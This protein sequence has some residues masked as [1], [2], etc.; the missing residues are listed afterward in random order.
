MNRLFGVDVA[1][2]GIKQGTDAA[3]DLLYVFSALEM[4]FDQEQQESRAVKD[5]YIPV[6]GRAVTW[7]IPCTI[8][9]EDTA[10]PFNIMSLAG[11]QVLVKLANASA[12]IVGYEGVATVMNLRHSMGD[13]AQTIAFELVGNGNLAI[14][15]TAPTAFA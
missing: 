2:Y 15:S 13:A 1:M 10:L 5:T 14:N 12:G 4:Q 7:R 11:K 8:Q 3:L 6:I 9:V